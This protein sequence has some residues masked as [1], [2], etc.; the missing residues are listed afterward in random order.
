ML[1]ASGLLELFDCLISNEDVKHPKPD[2]EMY[3]RA[4]QALG[5]KAEEVL[6]VEDAPHGVEAARRSGALVCQVSGFG[7]VDYARVRRA[8]ESA[9]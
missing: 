1:R 2:P 6:V 5:L 9:G 8:I 7:E 4:C 3:L